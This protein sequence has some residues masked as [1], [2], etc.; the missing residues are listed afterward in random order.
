M[1]MHNATKHRY[2]PKCEV[3]MKQFPPTRFFS[4]ALPEISPTFGEFS[5][6]S[7]AAVKFP[8]MSGFSRKVVTL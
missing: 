1:I 5:D 8:N 2:G 4:L 7:L 3:S 6:I